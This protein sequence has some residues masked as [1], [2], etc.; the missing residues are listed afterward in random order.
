MIVD[1]SINGTRVARELSELIDVRG[2]PE[3][4]LSDNERNLLVMLFCNG[5]MNQIG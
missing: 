4:I 2:K 5:H 3:C 1:T